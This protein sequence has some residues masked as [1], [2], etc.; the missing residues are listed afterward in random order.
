MTVADGSQTRLADVPEVTIGTTPPTPAFQ[1]MRYVSADIRLA[2]Q[3]DIPN[4]IRADRNVASIVDVGRTVQG[5]INTLL[6]YGT[7]DTWLARLFASAWATDV[8]KNGVT[9]AAGTLEMTFEQG[10]TDSYIRYRGVR[11]NTLDM[12]LVARQSVSANFG[13]MGIGS[14]TPTTA[15]ITDATYVPATT[16]EVFNAGLNVGSLVLSSTSLVTPPKMRSL[17][18]RIVNNIYANDV[19]GAYE[20]YS[21]GLGRFEVTGTA[22][23]YFES[24][25]VYTAIMAHED[26]AISFTLTDAAGNS[27]AFSI[28]K[29]KFLDGG[30]PVPGNGQAVLIECPFQ[31]IYDSSAGA[32]ISITREAA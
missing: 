29:A 1:V 9:H 31:G 4:E 8:L 6:S 7:Y 17:S 23:I 28:P 13:I 22:S 24:L 16:S 11:W 21:H 2:K 26:I 10:T 5:T 25:A 18:L 27:Y 12:N 14:P 32:T 15:I 30:P 19:V 20:T 3:T